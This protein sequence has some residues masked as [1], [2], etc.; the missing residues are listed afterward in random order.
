MTEIQLNT[1]INLFINLEKQHPQLI[2][3]YSIKLVKLQTLKP[4][5]NFIN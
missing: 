5:K 3:N 2:H 1:I 4:E